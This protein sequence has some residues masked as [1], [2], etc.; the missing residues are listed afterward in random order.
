[1]SHEVLGHQPSTSREEQL[2]GGSSCWLKMQLYLSILFL[3]SSYCPSLWVIIWI[4][5]SWY[6][7][8]KPIKY[9]LY[10]KAFF[11]VCFC[12]WILKFKVQTC[13]KGSKSSHV[14]QLFQDYRFQFY[15]YNTFVH[16]QSGLNSTKDNKTVDSDSYMGIWAFCKKLL[17]KIAFFRQCT[18]RVDCFHSTKNLV[19]SFQPLKL[20]K[21]T[22]LK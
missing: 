18:T 13:C 9:Y 22:F 4:C 1:M 14:L 16:T 11:S 17:N 20:C 5:S 19:A 2:Q 8:I 3:L 10:L 21:V 12:T 7:P 15:N 6:N